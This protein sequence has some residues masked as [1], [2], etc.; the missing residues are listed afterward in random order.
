MVTLGLN[1][2]VLNGWGSEVVCCLGLQIDGYYP[3]V[4][5]NLVGIIES[6]YVEVSEV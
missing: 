1:P 2:G 5:P 3:V 6:G 4:P